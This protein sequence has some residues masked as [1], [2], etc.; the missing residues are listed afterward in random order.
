MVRYTLYIKADL[1]GV[2]SLKLKKDADICISVV[3]PLNREEKRERVV[4]ETSN[5]RTPGVP[6][7]EKHRAEHPFH[8]ALKWEGEQN[9]S[10]IRVLD[11]P[12]TTR[13]MEER[14][15]FVP[16]LVFDCDGLEPCDFHP[17]GQEFVVVDKTGKKHDPV[18][19]SS[20]DWSAYDLSTGSTS[21]TNLRSK[22]V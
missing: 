3:N 10:T 5:L 16:V 13:D 12:A 21:V 17:M 1:E 19:L 2:S 14:D 9:R 4:I 22:F 6:A 8:F 15:S 18:D 20:G 7:H 11:E